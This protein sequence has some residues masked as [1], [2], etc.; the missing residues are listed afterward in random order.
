[1]RVF[2][3]VLFLP[4]NDTEAAAPGPL[5]RK[6]RTRGLIKRFRFL[7]LELQCSVDVVIV[8]DEK[9]SNKISISSTVETLLKTLK[10]SLWPWETVVEH[11]NKRTRNPTKLANLSFPVTINSSTGTTKNSPSRTLKSVTALPPQRETNE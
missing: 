2:I 7:R 11:S 8:A 9:Q 6:I 10:S 4:L 5:R 1:M 3:A